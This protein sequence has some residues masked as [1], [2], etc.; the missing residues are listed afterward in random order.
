M[1]EDPIE[2]AKL[3]LSRSI[4]ELV[5]DAGSIPQTFDIEYEGADWEV[6]VRV[7]STEDGDQPCST[8]RDFTDQ[9][10]E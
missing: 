9:L 4:V 1:R 5:W 3:S 10:P 2:A 8:E 6:V 7:K